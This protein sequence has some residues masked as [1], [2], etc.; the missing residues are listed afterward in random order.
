[1]F[2]LLIRKELLEQLLSLR[3]AM[4]CGICLAIMLSSIFVL[5]KDYQEALADY[6]TNVVM[7]GNEIEETQNLVWD[8]IKLDKPL[9]PMQ[10]FVRG[11]EEELSATA[12]VNAFTEPQFEVSYEGNPVVSLFPTIDLFYFVGVVMSLLAIAFSYDAVSGE[13]ELGTL[14]LLMSYSV[15]RDTVVLAKWIGGYLA[16]IAPFLL[17]FLSGLVVVILFPTVE[18]K[19]SHWSALALILICSLLYLAAIHSLGILVSAR[20]HLTSTSITDPRR[21]I[22]RTSSTGRRCPK[23]CP[24]RFASPTASG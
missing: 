6:R 11:V 1:M 22:D 7:H 13:K 14:K 4:A 15:P 2:F 16:M 19:E 24:A 5:A 23:A 20:T 12:K 18:L 3:F 8:G 9:N 10:I 21:G 17:S